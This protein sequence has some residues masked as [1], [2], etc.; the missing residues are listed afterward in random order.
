[1]IVRLIA[2]SGVE[3]AAASVTVPA[4]G[5][6]QINNVVRQLLYRGD[7]ANIANIDGYIRLESDQPIFG[8]ASQIENSTNDPGLAGQGAIRLLVQ[9]TTNVGSF[10]SS[11]GCQRGNFRSCTGHR[12]SQC[13]RRR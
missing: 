2:K 8:W 5:L 9:S 3:L 7:V 10:K 13:R 6:T 4:K 11:L 12:V 1:M